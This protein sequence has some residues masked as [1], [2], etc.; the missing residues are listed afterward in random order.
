MLLMEA[1]SVDFSTLLTSLGQVVTWLINQVGTVF[2]TI[3][4]YPVA[5]LFIGV[6]LGFVAV[7]F[8]KYIL[9]I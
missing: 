8:A 1:T 3:Q 6:S 9:N 4:M 7:K 2:N 5:L